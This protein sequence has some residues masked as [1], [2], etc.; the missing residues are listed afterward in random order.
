MSFFKRKSTRQ[1]NGP[2][3]HITVLSSFL[4]KNVST[5]PLPSNDC[6]TVVCLYSPY[7]A[8]GLHVRQC[9]ILHYIRFEVFM[10]VTMKMLRL[11]VLVR[12]DV[13]EEFST[14]VIRVTRIG[15]LGRKLAFSSNRRTLP[16]V[17]SSPILV[18]LMMET[19][20]CSETSVLTRSVRRNIPEDG[21]HL[22]ALL[23]SLSLLLYCIKL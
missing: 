14:S 7:S 20:G 4:V 17:P 12:T 5:E 18:T 19:V 21:I 16:N 13:S 10:A 8:I 6:C 2:F 22:T 1:L 9:D 3:F 23:L 15:E 11:A